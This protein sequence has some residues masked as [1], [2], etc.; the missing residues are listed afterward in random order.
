[1][2]SSLL[3]E[4]VRLLLSVKDFRA[5]VQG[6]LEGLI[7]EM[8]LETG[9]SGQEEYLAWTESLPTLARALSPDE[10]QDLHLHIDERNGL[11]LEY[12]LPA[13][14]YWCDAVLLGRSSER[15]S[16]VMVELKNWMTEYDSPGPSAGLINHAGGEHLHP[17]DQVRGYVEYCQ[18]FH[19]AVHAR[20]SAESMIR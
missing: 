2:Y 5:R 12:R 17:S 9:R 4:G 15:P 16:A 13:T 7:S 10:L 19:S 3:S 11:S 1:M 8:R 14:S 6:S 20:R 18:R